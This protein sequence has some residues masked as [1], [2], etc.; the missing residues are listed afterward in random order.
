M[1]PVS[2][3]DVGTVVVVVMVWCGVTGVVMLYGTTTVVVW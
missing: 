1:V 2:R 3:G